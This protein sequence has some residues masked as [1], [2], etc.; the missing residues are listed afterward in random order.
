M[1]LFDDA[2]LLEFGVRIDSTVSTLK[3]M[4]PSLWSQS[5]SRANE[6]FP[7]S[8]SL[9]LIV[10]DP[11]IDDEDIVWSASFQPLPDSR[12]F[13]VCDLSKGTGEIVS[14]GPQGEFDMSDPGKLH[15]W[16]YTMMLSS[17]G[18]LSTNIPLISREL[19]NAS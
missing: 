18:F 4:Y 13:F 3:A 19:G 1:I 17:L 7:F 10:G 8:M 6:R 2:D 9:S 11:V 15:S 12:L 16:A 5:G 14:E